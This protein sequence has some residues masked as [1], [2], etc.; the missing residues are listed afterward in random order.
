MRSNQSSVFWAYYPYP[1]IVQRYIRQR[2]SRQSTWFETAPIP[3]ACIATIEDEEGNDG[4]YSSEDMTSYRSDIGVSALPILA[5]ILLASC[6]LLAL[7]CL[8]FIKLQSRM[9]VAASCSFAL[10]AATHRSEKTTMQ[11]CCLS[12]GEMYFGWEVRLWIIDALQVR[13]WLAL[14]QQGIMRAP[15]TLARVG[16]LDAGCR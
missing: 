13:E 5:C 12:C 3:L 15:S 7:A 10:A 6:M 4:L 8:S 11:P 16:R 1:N 14:I 2:M 9:P